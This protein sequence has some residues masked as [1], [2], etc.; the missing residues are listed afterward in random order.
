M[1]KSFRVSS[2]GRLGVD[3]QAGFTQ[4][5]LFALGGGSY[6]AINHETKVYS[7]NSGTLTF[8]GQSLGSSEKP[9][10]EEPNVQSTILLTWIVGA[11]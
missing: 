2:C 1:A 4:Q 9:Q 8:D 11:T 3:P 10:G 7:S 6:G 5:Q